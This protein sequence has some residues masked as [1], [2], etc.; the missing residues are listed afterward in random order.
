LWFVAVSRR[1]GV[2]I[3][4]GLISADGSAR[5]CCGRRSAYIRAAIAAE[6][7]G[8]RN[9]MTASRTVDQGDSFGESQIS[10]LRF[11]I[12]FGDCTRLS[13]ARCWRT[14]LC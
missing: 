2:R 5:R 1:L 14:A 13:R 11:M 7:L 4:R 6:T 12:L 3:R 10:D 8:V 9:G